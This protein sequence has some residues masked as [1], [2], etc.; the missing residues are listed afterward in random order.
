MVIS[1]IVNTVLVAALV[2]VFVGRGSTAAERISEEQAI[3][4]IQ[5][6]GGKVTFDEKSAGKP[7]IAVDFRRTQV[8]YA[9][10]EHEKK[11][12]QSLTPDWRK[13]KSRTRD[14]SP[15]KA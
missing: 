11:L 12:L 14:L 2:V 15:S 8:T 5:K 13:L 4:E 9:V 3:A 10:L 7:V 6:L 1:R